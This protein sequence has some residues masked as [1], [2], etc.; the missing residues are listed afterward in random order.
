M[1]LAIAAALTSIAVVLMQ[2]PDPNSIKLR[3]IGVRHEGRYHHIS[4]GMDIPVPLDWSI[5][6][7]G[8]SSDD[9]EQVVLR[10]ARSPQVY[11]AIW[12]RHE[13]RKPA[14]IDGRL[15][16]SVPNKRQ[17]RSGVPGFAF[18]ASSIQRES[19]A[20]H[21]AERAI[22]DYREG[23]ADRVE[24]F[25]WVCTTRTLVQFDVRGAASEA[26]ASARAF[27]P[28]IQRTYIP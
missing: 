28:I 23:T 20:G 26:E 5:F 24:Y 10:Y 25:T 13:L 8:P 1:R 12:M 27:Q 3:A 19:I 21:Q 17:Q 2:P 15:Q 4:T 14:D 22:A 7:E 18:R 16:I 9:G 11:V 6:D